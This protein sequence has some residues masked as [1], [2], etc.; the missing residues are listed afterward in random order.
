MRNECEWTMSRIFS[1]AVAIAVLTNLARAEEPTPAS[2]PTTDAPVA[3][4]SVAPSPQVEREIGDIQRALG[5]SIVKEFP[6]L[7]PAPADGA[8][9]PGP[10]TPPVDVAPRVDPSPPVRDAVRPSPGRRPQA[11]ALRSAAAVL[12]AT[13]NRLEE[14]ELFEQADAVRDQAQQLRLDARRLIEQTESFDGAAPP[15]PTPA[16]PVENV[17]PGP[18]RFGLEPAA[19][20]PAPNRAE[21]R[22]PRD[23]AGPRVARPGEPVSDRG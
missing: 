11:S 12:D 13:A 23:E 7:A 17:P 6:S 4:D 14:A 21:P 20:P 16:W 5:G 22:L 9:M 15:W 3:E 8:P 10:W 18:R 1:A 2:A 19:E